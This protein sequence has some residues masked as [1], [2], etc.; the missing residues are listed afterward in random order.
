MINDYVNPNVI[1][2]TT[3]LALAGKIDKYEMT[4]FDYIFMDDASYIST[5][6]ALIILSK[7]PNSK[8]CY[9]GDSQQLPPLRLH[10]LN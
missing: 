5:T 1:I 9:L 8:V 7:F 6:T 3:H 10:N 4:G 2:M